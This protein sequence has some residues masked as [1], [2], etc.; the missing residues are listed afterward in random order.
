MDD[1][2]ETGDRDH[3]DGD[4]AGVPRSAA[5]GAELDAI[6]AELGEMHSMMGRILRAT[7][8]EEASPEMSVGR[9]DSGGDSEL[10]VRI[11]I[12]RM[13][14]MIGKAK[15]EI[16]HIK[17]PGADNNRMEDARSELDAIIHDTAT[18]TD[19]ILGQ[20]EAQMDLLTR[21]AGTIAGDTEAEALC[22]RIEA[23]TIKIMEACNFQDLTGQRTSKVIATLRHIEE[24][25]VA[26]IGIWG[27]EAFEDLP[28]PEIER[29]EDAALLNG[30][31]RAGEGISQAD[32]DALFD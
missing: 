16:A 7:T 22:S 18:A 15:A 29:D 17:H 24:R 20:A 8:G 19:E 21:L 10:A 30:P 6:R 4:G 23:A 3:A 1:G 32:I 28:I 9:A 31:A 14:K 27:I 13:V 26:M 5:T 11:E 25:I 12:A 2:D